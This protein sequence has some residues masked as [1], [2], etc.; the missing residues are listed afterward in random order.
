MISNARVGVAAFS[1]SAFMF[2]VLSKGAQEYIRGGD[3]MIGAAVVEAVVDA[4]TV[5][6]PVGNRF[7][8]KM[9][10]LGAQPVLAPWVVSAAVV[11]P[12]S[13]SSLGSP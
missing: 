3:V 11:V 7:I 10:S 13:H 2:L 4:V 5:P 1:V 9:E 12:Q 6:V 8:V